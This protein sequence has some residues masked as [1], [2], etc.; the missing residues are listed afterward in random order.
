[1]MTTTKTIS[2]MLAV[3][4]LCHG[5]AAADRRQAAFDKYNI[6]PETSEIV[7]DDTLTRCQQEGVQAGQAL[8]VAGS[9]LM[10]VGVFIWPLLIV[11][12][13]LV[14]ASMVQSSQANGRCLENAGYTPRT[15]PPT[16]ASIQ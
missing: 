4:M 15:P 3:T 5:C 11:G 13:G 6:P 12:G 7:L 14:S 10:G 16:E 2:T 8:N 1:M 9:V